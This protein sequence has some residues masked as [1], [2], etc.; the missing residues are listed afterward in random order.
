MI[1]SIE[2]L[3]IF[4]SLTFF[5]IFIFIIYNFKQFIKKRDDLK[6]IHNYI[7]TNL[8]GHLI[9]SNKFDK[10]IN[11]KISIVIS[12]YNGEGYIK[13]ALLSIQNQDFKEIEIIIIDDCSTDNSIKIIRELMK[14]D[15]R[16]IFLQNKVNKGALFTKTRGILNAKG[17]YVMTL[18]ED[19]IYASND[20]FSI[21]Y[22]EAEKNDL[23]IVGFGSIINDINILNKKITKYNYFESQIISQPDISKR[24]YTKNKN[25]EIIRLNNVIWCFFF[26][27]QLF[28]ST[29][30]IIDNKYL[31]NVMNNHDDML[32]FFLLTRKARKLKQIKRLF[33]FVLL[34][35]NPKD[36]S[37]IY[38]IKEKNKGNSKNK[39]FYYLYYAEFL[40]QYTNNT[41]IDKEIA[42]YELES[43]FLNH[44]CRNNTLV[45]KMAFRICLLYLENKYIKKSKKEKIK[46]F[47]DEFN[48]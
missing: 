42:T 39:C 41:Y 18:D 31:N 6:E 22:D 48:K 7:I 8:N 33:H 3:K 38:Q 25:G 29:I 4:K 30:K 36:S 16:I 46:S 13:T 11:P 2:K 15:Q 14:E 26:K 20:A 27:T 45:R 5:G 28:I 1:I 24:M 43:W 32:L 17:K 34:R 47:I 12:V 44:E 19:D 10:V 23:D 21:L 9:N 37:I 40:L 35:P